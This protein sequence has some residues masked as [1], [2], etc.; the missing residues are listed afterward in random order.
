MSTYDLMY[1]W[2][3]VRDVF[4]AMIQMSP[5]LMVGILVVLT[6]VVYFSFSK[7]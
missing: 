4:Q 7:R 3:Q 6:G 5:P 2:H 1:A